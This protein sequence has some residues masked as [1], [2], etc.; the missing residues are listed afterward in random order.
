MFF[1]KFY[2]SVKAAYW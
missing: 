1:P 2:P